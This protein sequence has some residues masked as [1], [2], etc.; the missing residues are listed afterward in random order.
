MGSTVEPLLITRTGFVQY[1]D[2]W[3]ENT[4]V[5]TPR[6]GLVVLEEFV[7]SASN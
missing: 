2:A 7:L 6:H 1:A 5:A 4:H 3:T